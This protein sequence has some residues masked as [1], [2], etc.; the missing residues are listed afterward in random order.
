MDVRD[1]IVSKM[2][3]IPSLPGVVATVRRLVQNQDVNFDELADS[4]GMDQGLTANLLRLANSA[5][6]G[7][8]RSI[9]SV[10]EALVRLGTQRIYH[11]VLGLCVAPMARKRVKG[12]DLPAG[13]LWAHAVATA[14]GAESM[15]RA[16][17]LACPDHVFTAGLLHDVGKLVL[18][19]FVEVNAEPIRALAFDEGVP[20]DEAERRVLGIDHAE[21]GAL[22]LDRWNLPPRIV[23]VGR[24]HHNPRELKGDRLVVDLVH[25]ADALCLE[26]GLGGG[27]EGVQCRASADSTSRLGVTE[28]KNEA[29][30]CEIIAGVE[31]LSD[32]IGGRPGA[33]R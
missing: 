15:A 5:Y 32:L 30:V 8:Q 2:R 29:V 18:G 6:F 12:Y 22:L 9:G 25:T 26:A 24:W 33:F 17:G 11:L 27:G 28:E 21:V 1:A 13:K 10:Q 7:F 31:E 16:L 19:T 14:V 3:V 23:E 4:I 20:F